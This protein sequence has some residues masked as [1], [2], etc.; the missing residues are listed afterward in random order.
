MLPSI[1]V[2]VIVSGILMLIL[3]RK[4]ALF[5]FFMASSYVTLGQRIII[6]GLD[7]TIIRILV[8]FGVVRIILRQSERR[9]IRNELD[10]AVLLWGI[11]MVV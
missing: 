7:F 4:F 3:D 5:P 9:F 6:A 2:L 10:T 11:V 8:L 1:I